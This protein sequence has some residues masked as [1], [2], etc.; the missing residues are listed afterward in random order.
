MKLVVI[1]GTQI[2]VQV[3][4]DSPLTD[5]TVVFA[6][7]YNGKRVPAKVLN[8]MGGA[9]PYTVKDVKDIE[10]TLDIVRADK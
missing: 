6:V 8:E 7:L 10:F 3:A 2:A 1:Q 5:D 4:D 9:L